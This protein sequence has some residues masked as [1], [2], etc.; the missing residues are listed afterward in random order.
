MPTTEELR[1]V[2]AG[3]VSEAKAGRVAPWHGVVGIAVGASLWATCAIDVTGV[4]LIDESIPGATVARLSSTD[5]LS[6]WLV[7]GVD[8]THL[9]A[10]GDLVIEGVYFDVLLLSKALNLRPDRRPSADR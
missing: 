10:Q 3:L 8:Y 4:H 6:S 5:A 9:V 1:D 7:D 2:L